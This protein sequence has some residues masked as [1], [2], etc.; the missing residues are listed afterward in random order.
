ME[1]GTRRVRRVPFAM[2]FGVHCGGRFDAFAEGRDVFLHFLMSM[3]NA[4]RCAKMISSFRLLNPHD[5][6]KFMGVTIVASNDLR[7]LKFI[8]ADKTVM[9]IRV[10]AFNTA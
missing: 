5:F 9:F 8:V 3:I 4:K 2:V 6:G 7:F 1:E 10:I